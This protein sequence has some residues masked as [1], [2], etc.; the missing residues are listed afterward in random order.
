[1]EK[2]GQPARPERARPRRGRRKD[3][4]WGPHG[5]DTL[6]M[7]KPVLAIFLTLVTSGALVGGLFRRACSE[8]REPV[9]R[10]PAALHRRAADRGER[11]RH[12][13]RAGRACARLDPRHAADL[14]SSFELP[15]APGLR[16]PSGEAKA[17]ITVWASRSRQFDGDLTVV[18]PFEGTPAYR[19]GIRAGDIISK[20]EGE[21]TRG[22]ALDGAVKRLRGPKGS[23]VT[24]SITRAGYDQ[25]LDFTIVR[26][27]I[28]LRSVPYFF[29]LEDGVGY[30][31]LADFTETTASEL[32]EA[33]TTL[34]EQNARGLVLDCATIRAV[35]WIR[36][37][38]CLTSSSRRARSSSTREVARLAPIR[39][40]SPT[41]PAS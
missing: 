37:C 22:M 17:A 5:T 14:G 12:G 39:S 29:N 32:E 10:V 13:G 18:S 24:I 28:R 7:R 40:T 26:D 41:V 2:T 6:K 31:R 35:S 11:V 4:P 23:A 27:E 21:E 33:L 8:D 19:L 9:R 20:I 1:M 38:R 34:K 36:P 30:I 16:Q 3:E 15:R 25:P